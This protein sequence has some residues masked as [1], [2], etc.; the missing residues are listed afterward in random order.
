MAL[1]DE[2]ASF[3]YH[4]LVREVLRAEVRARDRGREQALQARAGEWFQA[5]GDARRAVRHFFAARQADRA[6]ALLQERMVDDFLRDPVLPPPL[7]LS[8]V[9]PS[10]LA[11]APDRLLAVAADLVVAGDTARSWEY[12]GLLERAQPAIPPELRRPLSN[13]SRCCTGP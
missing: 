5:A 11:A 13:S 7:D 12:L 1:D 9:D 4:H 2:Q 8:T 10:L 3:R 6:L